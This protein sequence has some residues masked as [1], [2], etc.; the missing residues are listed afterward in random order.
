[1]NEPSPSIQEKNQRGGTGQPHDEELVEQLAEKYLDQ[2]LA[3]QAPDRGRLLAAHADIAAALEPRLSL[4]ELMHRMAQA[5]KQAG[6]STLQAPKASFAERSEHA[7]RFQCPHCGNRIQLIEA[8]RREV[9]CQSCGS[10]FQIEPRNTASYHEEELPKRIGKLEVQELIGRGAF[11]D[12]FK[13]RDP[14][15]ARIVAIKLPRAGYFGSLAEEERF[16]REARSAAQLS[17]PHIVKVLD[18]AHEHGLPFIVSD[19]VEGLTLADLLTGSRPGFRDSAELVLRIAEALDYAHQRKIIH[20]DIKPSNILI[21]ATGKPHLTDFGLSRR[22]EGE[23]TVTLDGQ[24]IGTPAY[25][26]PEQ[27]AGDQSQVDGRSDVYSLGVV[28]YELLTGELPFRGNKRM[29]LHQVLHDDPRPPRSLN[30]RIPRDLE[31]ICLK[32]MAKDPPRRYV[33][34]RDL[35]DDLGRYL[36]GE[37]IRAKPV[38]QFERTIKWARRRPVAAALLVVS[39]LALAALVG[40]G[41]AMFYNSRLQTALDESLQQKGNAEAQRQIADQARAEAYHQRSLVRRLLY[42]S[43]MG[44]AYRAWQDARITRVEELLDKQKRQNGEED[45]R[46]FEWHY[47]KGLLS[48]GSLLTLKGHTAALEC[49]TFSSD[50]KRIASG[51]SDHTARIWDADTGQEILTIKCNDGPVATVAFSPDGKKL[52]TGTGDWTRHPKKI[53]Q[54]KIWDAAT[55]REMLSLQGHS[56]PI[57]GVAFSSDGDQL[58]S[59]SSD[60]SV[61]VWDLQ[62][63]KPLFSITGETDRMYQVAFSPDGKYIAGSDGPYVKL[64]DKATGK[65]V[66]SF[67]P[68]SYRV[69]SMAFNAGGGLLAATGN[70]PEMLFVWNLA[71]GQKLASLKPQG[72]TDWIRGVA[73]SPD[74]Q[75]LATASEDRTVR[76]WDAHDLREIQSFKGHADRVH[77]V[78]FNPD[79]KRVA[80]ACA[81][82]TIKIWDA[83]V[84]QENLLCKGDTDRSIVWSLSFSPDSQRLAAGSDQGVEVFD[85][86][87]GARVSSFAGGHSV[88]FSPDGKRLVIPPRI[89]DVS[90]Q[91]ILTLKDQRK[92]NCVA[93]SPDGKRLACGYGEFGQPG[94]D[95]K[96]VEAG[97]GKEEFTLRGHGYMVWSLAFSPQGDYLASASED[98]TVKIWDLATG[99]EKICLRGHTSS[100][101][102]VAFDPDGKRLATASADKS[103]KLWNATTGQAILTIQGHPSPV[104]SVAF[105]PDG[106]RLASTADD[107]SV[108]LWDATT[109][110]EVLSF[111]SHGLGITVAFSPDGTRLARGSFPGPVMIWS[112]ESSDGSVPERERK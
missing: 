90:G 9:T 16:L 67:Q 77:S 58:A 95:V 75:R 30:D 41:V 19:Y 110:E 85:A 22:D 82:G 107:D 11:G 60:Q 89:W 6:G 86:T 53:G 66:R 74:G 28:L 51:G 44:T 69:K 108:K 48:H 62:T 81:D 49:V 35:T 2:L 111:L 100:I 29:L 72:H 109:G 8:D 80:S 4:V 36:M 97:T 38:G 76:I 40:A 70:L 88:A 18:I 102:G 24:I 106:K 32:A 46:S 83:T 56:G 12:V 78:A 64:W 54:L 45:L 59:A 55:G 39:G 98:Q 1:M 43:R 34:A 71:N 52:A 65:K 104:Y 93:F 91:E 101:R 42:L 15:L 17:H 31:T 84:A 23:I 103:I 99:Q 47:L 5:Q 63:G 105:S 3:G 37:P 20:R 92:A 112:A 10:S 87:K 13:A 26:S 14:E 25:M 33:T 68:G 96:I 94:G 61:K 50:G 79:G 27:A 73:F 7:V 21:D 57:N